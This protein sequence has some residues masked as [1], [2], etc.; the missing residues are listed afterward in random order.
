[1]SVVFLSLGC[2]WFFG[3][4]SRSLSRAVYIL[5]TQQ[6]SKRTI[7]D[8]AIFNFQNTIWFDML[9]SSYIHCLSLTH[10]RHPWSCCVYRS[11]SSTCLE[12]WASYKVS[13]C[14]LFFFSLFFLASAKHPR[15]NKFSARQ[16][17]DKEDSKKTRTNRINSKYTFTPEDIKYENKHY[18]YI[19]FTAND[20][21]TVSLTLLHTQ[22]T[23]HLVFF[24][25]LRRLSV[26]ESRSND[27][28]ESEH[29]AKWWCRVAIK[30]NVFNESTHNISTRNPR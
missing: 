3:N 29:A 16:P 13:S 20:R 5:H 23:F 11:L 19:K 25:L 22:S 26:G 24:F 12:K 14:Y 9:L 7:P 30:W 2:L 17:Q 28:S 21:E 27:Q 4:L 1:M 15:D 8:I 18:K 10:L 6:T